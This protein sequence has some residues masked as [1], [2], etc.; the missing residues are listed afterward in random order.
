ML[1]ASKGDSFRDGIGNIQNRL[2]VAHAQYAPFG[3]DFPMKLLELCFRDWPRD[4][5]WDLFIGD[6][7]LDQGRIATAD[8]VTAR[9]S[10]V[11]R[12]VY[13]PDIRMSMQTGY[14][15]TVF[16][17][18]P[19]DKRG[20]NIPVLNASL[21][22]AAHLVLIAAANGVSIAQQFGTQSEIE[23]AHTSFERLMVQH[24]SEFR[25]MWRQYYLR[26]VADFVTPSGSPGSPRGAAEKQCGE[27]SRG[28]GAGGHRHDCKEGE[29]GEGRGADEESEDGLD[30]WKTQWLEYVPSP[31]S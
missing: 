12:G 17:A 29:G 11:F 9:L 31:R 25:K 24:W 2:D 19:S 7:V 21:V 1:D 8:A 27:G 13:E 28:E 10:A 14:D 30:V 18:T 4:V 22:A 20:K 5:F 6:M 3:A 15:P 16:A 23:Q 26:R